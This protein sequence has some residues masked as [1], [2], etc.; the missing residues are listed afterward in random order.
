MYQI[1]N[2]S[3]NIL[4]HWIY[5]FIILSLY[6]QIIIST[7]STIVI[8]FCQANKDSNEGGKLS[9]YNFMVRKQW[10]SVLIV[11][12]LKI[13]HEFCWSMAIYLQVFEWVSIYILIR[14]EEKSSLQEIIYRKK[15]TVNEQ[16][17]NFNKFEL[18]AKRIFIASILALKTIYYTICIHLLI[19]ATE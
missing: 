2:V 15:E 1:K 14:F 5:Q 11:T 3:L 9:D 13:I 19:T 16:I 4:N 10:L 17:R 8:I 6:L 12:L 7:Y 18:K